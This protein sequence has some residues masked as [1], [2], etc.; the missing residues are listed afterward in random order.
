MKK[1]NEQDPA[2]I[3]QKCFH[4]PYCPS[5]QCQNHLA[6]RIKT[7]GQRYQSKGWEALLTYPFFVKRFRCLDCRTSFRYSTF[8]LEHREK[9]R[10]LNSKIFRFFLCGVSNREIGRQLNC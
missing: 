5:T 1:L 7:R 3:R 9:R 8:K 10:G 6:W 4:P 2:I